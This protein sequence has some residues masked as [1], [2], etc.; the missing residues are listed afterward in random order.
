MTEIIDANAAYHAAARTIDGAI[1]TQMFGKPCYTAH[2]TSFIS[3]FQNEAAFKLGGDAHAAALALEGAKLFDPSQ[4]GRPFK[5]W[6]QIP[7]THVVQWPAY[8]RAAYDFAC[9]T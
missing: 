1:E 6:V 4:K 7:A 8:A 9:N 5:A 2:K 3:F